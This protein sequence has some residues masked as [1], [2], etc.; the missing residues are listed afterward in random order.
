MI[1]LGRGITWLDMGTCESL[2]QANSYVNTIEKDRVLKL[3]V[4]KKLLGEM[5]GSPEDFEN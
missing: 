4:Q 5:D 3:V 2:L 1:E